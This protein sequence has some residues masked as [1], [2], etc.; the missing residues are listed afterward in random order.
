MADKR[1][2]YEVLGVSKSA[3]DDEL[4]HA[5]RALA[6]KYHPD[7]HP[8][9]K[10][11]EAKFKEINEA[12]EVLSDKD[13]R[14]KYDQ[15]GF[16]EVDPTYGAGQGG[17][18]YGSYGS[19]GFGGFSGFGDVGDIFESFF[20]GGFGGSQRSNP[21]ASRRG[22]D[23][24]A[25]LTISFM[26]ACKGTRKQVKV[27]RYESCPDCHGTGAKAGTSA[28]TCPDC[29][30]TGTVKVNQRTAFGVFQTTRPCDKCGGKGKIIKSVCPTCAGQGRVRS[31]LQREVEIPAGIDDGQTLKVQGAGD[32]GIN[33][34]GYGDLNIKVTVKPD[35]MFERE[36]F[37]V[38]T[39]IPISYT[40]A[41]LGDEI[42]VPTIDGNVK[43]TVPAGTQT[44]TVFRLRGKGIK[45][46]YRTDRGDQY[47]TVKVEVPRNLTKKQADLLK[48]FD[49]S[50]DDRN[51]ASKKSFFEKMKDYLNS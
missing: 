37:D 25:N 31:V 16:A 23:I 21:N 9:D 40:Q 44:G 5:F 42:V 15:F 39:E 34:G 46:L 26:E 35:D 6:K 18:A 48:A 20:G 4:K 32:S 33:G 13:K 49:D 3:T 41:T 7:L 14:A 29:R 43:Y 1:D 2:Y 28:E 17:G 24:R 36:G 10:D 38:Y 50:L 51:Q 47:V 19:S 27:T 8:D 45:R 30:G 11:A 12:Y 22:Q